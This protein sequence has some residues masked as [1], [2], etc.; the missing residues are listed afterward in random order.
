MQILNAQ[1][2]YFYILVDSMVDVIQTIVHKD[3]G[4]STVNIV[5]SL[6]SR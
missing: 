6:H 5:R 4:A 2:V 3:V 1:F